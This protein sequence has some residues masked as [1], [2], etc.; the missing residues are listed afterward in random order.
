MAV[1]YRSPDGI[2]SPSGECS[3]HPH[4]ATL[5]EKAQSS[6]R[7]QTPENQPICRSYSASSLVRL[8][9]SLEEPDNGIQ[10]ARIEMHSD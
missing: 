2:C 10:A 6:Y 9:G 5:G 3:D 8:A 4:N 7:Q 1:S